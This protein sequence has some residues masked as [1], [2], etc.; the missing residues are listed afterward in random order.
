[1]VTQRR[2][3]KNEK[4]DSNKLTHKMFYPCQFWYSFHEA[5][6]MTV[7]I[8]DYTS[9]QHRILLPVVKK[10]NPKHFWRIQFQVIQIIWK[11]NN[12]IQPLCLSFCT[13]HDFMIG[14]IIGCISF[15]KPVSYVSWWRPQAEAHRLNKVALHCLMFFQMIL[16]GRI[17]IL[18]TTVAEICG[19]KILVDQNCRKL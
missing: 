17:N 3:Q 7:I 14:F 1:M 2:R 12:F 11:T 4:K 15:F 13:H 10:N 5:R 19:L 16:I 6:E 8:F 18:G 9:R